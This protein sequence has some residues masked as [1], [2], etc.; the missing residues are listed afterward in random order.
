[1]RKFLLLCALSCS[2]IYA[3]PLDSFSYESQKNSIPSLFIGV[4]GQD[5]ILLMLTVSVG[6]ADEISKHGI[7]NLVNYILQAHLKSRCNSDDIKYGI[8]CNG[9]VGYDQS[10]YYFYMKRDDLDAVIKICGDVFSHFSCSD[11]ICNTAKENI[12]KVINEQS[13]IDKLN[14]KQE[15]RRA[16]YWHAGYGMDPIGT[17]S[18]LDSITAKNVNDFVKSFYRNSNMHMIIVG[19]VNKKQVLDAIDKNFMDTQGTSQ[20]LDRLIEPTHHGSTVQIQRQSL[21]T[22]ASVIDIYWKVP[23]YKDDAQAALAVDIFV[24]YLKQMVQTNFIETQL[25][26][27]VSFSIA[28]WNRMYGDFCITFSPGPS[29]DIERLLIMI[30]NAIKFAASEGLQKTDIDDA[31]K[32]II[33]NSN[34]RKMDVI[35]A[36]DWISKKIGAGYN[37]EFL[38]KYTDFVE[39]YDIE[40]V[41]TAIKKIFFEDPC[42]VCITS[43]KE[44]NDAL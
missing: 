28:N 43:P 8:E 38:K 13:Q 6:S 10:V 21:Q 40:K 14:L 23:S 19:A 37:F 32:Q 4:N 22:N 2:T 30:K 34:F 15:A 16:L 35:D 29:T 3:A 36:I 18:S 41:N 39:H 25:L 20:K 7:A 12:K 9:Y 11:A 44:T 26:S 17:I 42:V 27:S 5:S 24:N 33:N 1:M 31:I